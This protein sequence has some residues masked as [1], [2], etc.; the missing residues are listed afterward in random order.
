MGHRPGKIPVVVVALPFYY[1]DGYDKYD[2]IMQ[3]LTEQ[4][5]DWEIKLIR[6]QSNAVRFRSLLLDGVDG[7]I[8]DVELAQLLKAFPVGRIPLVTLDMQN[9]ESVATVGRNLVQVDSDSAEIGR[10]AA[11][12]LMSQGNYASYGYVGTSA[13]HAWSNERGVHFERRLRQKKLDVRN[14]RISD[15]Q[16]RNWR[17]RFAVWLKEAPKPMAILAANDETAS[18]ILDLCNRIGINV[19]D[20]VGV[21]GVDNEKL[22]CF[23]SRPTLSSVQPDFKT[24]GY[25]AARALDLLMS[26]KRVPRRIVCKV[27]SVVARRSTLSPS[28]AGRLVQLADEVISANALAK[29]NVAD[30][31]RRLKVS[32]R[33]LDLRYRQIKGCSV[34]DAIRAAR[35]EHAKFLLQ[36]T[37]LPMAD[38]AS[39]SGFS[40]EA[41]FSAAFSKRLGCSPRTF[42]Q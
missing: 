42:R 14:F 13:A 15:V 6:E 4:D 34:L 23:H 35:I 20:E 1:Q 37:T 39:Q 16:L 30:V 3:Y 26:G 9:A 28:S 5:I 19:P 36:T 2:G 25:R 33:L 12:Y 38:V 22:T 8:V 31:A 40:S 17:R 27:K 11:E 24:E 41:Y 32:R 10:V 18:E 21:L 29:L 7:A